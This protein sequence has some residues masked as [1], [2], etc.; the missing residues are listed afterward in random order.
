MQTSKLAAHV[1][2]HAVTAVTPQRV[3][4]L[5]DVLR[6]PFTTQV[7]KLATRTVKHNSVLVW[8]LK[9]DFVFPC[10]FRFSNINHVML[11]RRFESLS[12]SLK[13]L[14]TSTKMSNFKIANLTF[15]TCKWALNLTPTPWAMFTVYLSLTTVLWNSPSAR[16]TKSGFSVFSNENQ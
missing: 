15:W 9:K 3:R 1:R 5:L 6:R 16:G 13:G 2:L 10:R 11:S 12:C 7:N 8:P 4:Q 14:R